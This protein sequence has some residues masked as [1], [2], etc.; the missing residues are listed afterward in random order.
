MNQMIGKALES[1]SNFSTF[2]VYCNWLAHEPHIQV[3]LSHSDFAYYPVPRIAIRFIP[4]WG[5]VRSSI[6]LLIDC[7]VYTSSAI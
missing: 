6:S 7:A 4:L 2:I 5:H 1:K 3:R